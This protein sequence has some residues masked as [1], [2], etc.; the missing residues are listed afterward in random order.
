M[1]GALWPTLRAVPSSCTVAL[2]RVPG[3]SLQ[4]PGARAE[5]VLRRSGGFW[6]LQ[7]NWEP[8]AGQALTQSLSARIQIWPARKRSGW[9]RSREKPAGSAPRRRRSGGPGEAG[10][11]AAGAH[12]A[13]GVALPPSGP[14]LGAHPQ[15]RI[16]SA[17]ALPP[18]SLCLTQS[19]VLQR[20]QSFKQNT[21]AVGTGAVPR[22]AVA[23][24]A[25]GEWQQHLLL[26]A[27]LEPGSPASTGG[28]NMEWP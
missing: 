19:I 16:T 20:G 11:R 15:E 26:R 5:R 28:M 7:S 21:S 17:P 18:A 10:G 14:L 24:G 13:V 27:R 12:G 8:R 6:H 22:R 9:R 25:P 2:L 4:H 23:T 3:K 1:P